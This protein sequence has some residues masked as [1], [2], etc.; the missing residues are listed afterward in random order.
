MIAAA[1]FTP[2]ASESVMSTAIEA[3][4]SVEAGDDRVPVVAVE[5]DAGRRRHEAHERRGGAVFHG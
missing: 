5:L 1:T 2:K 3:V 4:V